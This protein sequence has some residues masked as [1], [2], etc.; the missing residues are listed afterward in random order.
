MEKPIII[1][2]KLTL[3]EI[4]NILK[5]SKESEE[6]QEES[7]MVA[8]NISCVNFYECSVLDLVSPLLGEFQ[9]HYSD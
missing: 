3:D 1:P 9:I 4:N 5:A 8:E 2:I 6:E 7:D